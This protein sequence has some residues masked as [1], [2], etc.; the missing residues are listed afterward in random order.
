[1]RPAVHGIHHVTGIVRDGQSNV[2]FY[3]DALGLRFVKRTVDFED[4]FSYHLHYGD[5][6][7]SAGSVLTFF[8]FLDEADGRVGRP[9]IASTA[10]AVPDQSL[11][12]W[13]SRLEDRGAVVGSI[14]RRFDERALSVHDPDGTHIE[15]V[16]GT[17]HA[18]PWD[19]SVP[20]EHG[21]RGV[22]GVSVLSASPYITASILETFGF[23]RGGQDGTRVRYRTG[24]G[25]VDILDRDTE[26]GREGA[27][28]IHHV[29]FGVDDVDA[30]HA[31]R[32]TLAGRDDVRVSYVHDRDYYHSLYVRDAGGILFELATEPIE[33]TAGDPSPGEHLYLP[34]QFEEDRET[35]ESQ[36]PR[37]ELP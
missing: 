3:S 33:M 11:D 24:R 22:A 4:R 12:Y 2:D 27:G 37:I 30:L 21:I 17:G 35:I 16:A 8:P 25:V 18:E 1:M 23:T 9:Q 26:Y 34:S 5:A 6:T 15:L 31:W 14:D 10:L 7:G 29:A 20:P 28:T 19:G 13:R 32:E 36:L